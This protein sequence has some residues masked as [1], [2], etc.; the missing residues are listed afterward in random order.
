MYCIEETMAWRERCGDFD[1]FRT[2]TKPKRLETETISK[3]LILLGRILKEC[4]ESDW[5]LPIFSP[6][7]KPVP[8]VI[9][10]TVLKYADHQVIDILSREDNPYFVDLLG[11]FLSGIERFIKDKGL[12]C[13]INVVIER[14]PEAHDNYWFTIILKTDFKSFDEQISRWKSIERDNQEIVENYLKKAIS[15]QDQKQIKVANALI[16]TSVISYE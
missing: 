5:N 11:E 10:I 12:D 9:P 14:E 4:R 1:Y 16:A 3:G 7:P 8:K 2:R 15:E 13:E 6:V